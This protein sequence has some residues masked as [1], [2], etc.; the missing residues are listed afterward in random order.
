VNLTFD[1]SQRTLVATHDTRMLAEWPASNN[2][3][4]HSRGPWP[5]GTYQPRRIIH[6]G[7]PDGDP[8][9]AFGPWFLLYD[10]PGRSG[11]GIHAGREGR[12][13]LAGRL[14]HA[15]ATLG[16]IRTTTEAMIDLE[17]LCRAHGLP[18]L[19]V[20]PAGVA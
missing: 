17:S 18:T 11:M 3:A 7:G 1:R 14:D 8:P 13:D 16:C 19:D 20:L 4:R 2:A 12:A 5:A 6:V 10:V 15:H 9:G